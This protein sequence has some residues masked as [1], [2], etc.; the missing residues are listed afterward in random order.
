MPIGMKTTLPP[1]PRRL[2]RLMTNMMKRKMRN[3]AIVSSSVASCSARMS[4][5]FGFHSA[6][7]VVSAVMMSSTP[8]VTPPSK[9]PAL[10]RGAMALAMMMLDTASVSV[11]SRP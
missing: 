7:S 10:K 2:I 5:G 1:P 3:G 8:R 9:S 4:V 11:P 6:E